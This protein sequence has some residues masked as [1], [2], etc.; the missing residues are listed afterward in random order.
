MVDGE[1]RDVVLGHPVLAQLPH[2]GP[3]VVARHLEDGEAPDVGQQGVPHGAGEV[4]QLGQAL[5]GEDEGG[6]EL[7]ELRQHAFVVHAG[8]RL[9]LVHDDQ[10]APALVQRQ[11]SLLPYHGVHEVQEGSAH[12]G[13]HVAAHGPLGR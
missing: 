11:P 6:P 2:Q 13:G 1:R 5:G 3:G 7:A 8:H 10:R 12:Q 4:V 9:H